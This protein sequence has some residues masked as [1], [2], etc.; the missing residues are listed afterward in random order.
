MESGFDDSALAVL[1]VS[2]LQK[3]SNIESLMPSTS[4]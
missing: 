3:E 2:E 1:A 4:L